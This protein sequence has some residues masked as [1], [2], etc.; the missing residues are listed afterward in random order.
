[1]THQDKHKQRVWV[2][3]VSYFPHGPEGWDFWS[4]HYEQA[5]ADAEAAAQNKE[6]LYEYRVVPYVPEE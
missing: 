5:E 3:E 1:M 6:R 4:A 2:V